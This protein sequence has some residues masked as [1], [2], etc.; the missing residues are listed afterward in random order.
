LT[1]VATGRNGKLLVS[2]LR[3]PVPFPSM[4]STHC[5]ISSLFEESAD[6]DHLLG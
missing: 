2:E 6:A 4:T 3:C 5:P 1:V